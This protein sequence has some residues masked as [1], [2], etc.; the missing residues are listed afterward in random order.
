MVSTDDFHV[1]CE[2]AMIEMQ[3]SLPGAENPSKGWDAHSQMVGARKFL[4]YLLNLT[5]AANQKP[6]AESERLDSI[7]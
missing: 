5:E 4:S 7:P 3:I 1:A 6:K 2:A